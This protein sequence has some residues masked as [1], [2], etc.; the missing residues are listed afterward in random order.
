MKNSIKEH[1]KEFLE[2]ESKA[3]NRLK[4]KDI[5]Y[6]DYV[7]LRFA[8]YNQYK[9]RS[10][11]K[12]K[13]FDSLI[14]NYFFFLVQAER[15]IANEVRLF[16]RDLGSI[17]LLKRN[18]EKFNVRKDKMVRKLILENLIEIKEAKIIYKDIIEL[19]VIGEDSKKYILHCSKEM[20]DKINF[21][22]YTFGTSKSFER[23]PYIAF[24]E[25]LK[26]YM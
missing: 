23:A 20:L 11:A 3:L 1:Q 12:A 5:S 18:L 24:E 21:T 26:Q 15:R 16:Q 14:Y 6:E 7:D 4:R 17:D 13:E 8:Y 9:L 19:V 25:Y 2:V 10:I 22:D